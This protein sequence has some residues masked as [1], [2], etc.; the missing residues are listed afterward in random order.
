[1]KELVD[2][3][4]EN[5]AIM[6][7]A[8]EGENFASKG[9]Q[10]YFT[11]DSPYLW[12]KFPGKKSWDVFDQILEQCN[13]VTTPGSGFGSAGESFIRFSAFGHRQDVEEACRR[14]AN[15]KI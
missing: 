10:V 4:L 2:Y 6:K 11:G 9:V 5:A 1:T 3:Y 14:L 7:K 12:V 15:F 8:L 13:V